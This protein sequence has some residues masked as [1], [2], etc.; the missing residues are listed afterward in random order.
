[1]L[2][3]E[4][5]IQIKA[6]DGGNGHVSFRR[7]KFVPKGGPD[8][9]RGGD[10]GNLYF[11][12]VDDIAALARYRFTKE[13]KAENGEPG[14]K[15]KR[16]GSIGSDLILKV[17]LGTVI[18]DTATGEFWEIVDD[19]EKILLVKGGQGGWG[20]HHFRSATNQTPRE[21]EFGT[22]GQKREL[23][24]ELRLI[25]DVGI[26]GL[27]SAGKSSLLN[28]LTNAGAKVAPYHF[29]TLEP[30]LGVMDRL[31]L[32]DLPGLIEG[33][34][35]G[36]G[37][38]IRFLK[39]VKRTR[40]II[41]CL[42]TESQDPLKD[43]EVIRKEL[44]E[45]DKEL[46]LKPEILVLTKSDLVSAKEIKE[47]LKKLKPVKKEVLPASIHDLDSLEKLKNVILQLK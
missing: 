28:E 6:G 19:Q 12:G 7:E 21:F 34:S 30:N 2:V 47:I 9:G 33:A 40:I 25:A 4:V 36:K 43:Y 11:Q 42:S 16:T 20:N 1:M 26:I 8:G 45:Y 14:S 18:K 38:G 24:M 27:P 37:L 5:V 31:I 22:Y 39:H 35:T 15:A 32:A 3:D 29:T 13:F 44:G 17:P 46:L 23:F 41:H 10:G